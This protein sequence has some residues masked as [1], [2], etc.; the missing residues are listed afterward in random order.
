MNRVQNKE[1]ATKVI[2]NHMHLLY[3][4]RRYQLMLHESLVDYWDSMQLINEE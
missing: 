3:L 2:W 4:Y 1:V